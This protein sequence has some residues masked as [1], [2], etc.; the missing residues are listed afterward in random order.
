M[1]LFTGKSAGVDP[2]K[3]NINMGRKWAKDDAISQC[4]SYLDR[5]CG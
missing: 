5:L 2:T 1:V 4:W 3:F